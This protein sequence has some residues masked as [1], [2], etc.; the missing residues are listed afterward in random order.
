MS[1]WAWVILGYAA[2]SVGITGYFVVL[3][4]RAGALRR[5]AEDAG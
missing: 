1:E 4:R 2:T 3:L 5:R